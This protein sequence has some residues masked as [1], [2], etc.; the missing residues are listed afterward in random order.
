MIYPNDS[1]AAL[2][3]MEIDRTGNYGEYAFDYNSLFTCPVCGE[4]TDNL[5]KSSYH[6]DEIVGCEYCIYEY[7]TD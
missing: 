4:S 3:A 1:D 2:V 7:S 5:Y 6:N